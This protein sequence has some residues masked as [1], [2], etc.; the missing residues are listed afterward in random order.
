MRHEMSCDVMFRWL[1]AS[2]QWIAAVPPASSRTLRSSDPGP[3]PASVPPKRRKAPARPRIGSGA[4]SAGVRGDERG[5][6]SIPSRVP[7]FPS[8]ANRPL[9]PHP[10]SFPFVPSAP[11]AGPPCGG[12]LFR[13]Y[14]VRPC[15]CGRARVG[16][17]AVRA[18]DC[19]CPRARW[20][21]AGRTCPVSFSVVFSRRREPK[22][23]PDAAS[24][25][26]I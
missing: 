10:V 7:G 2:G 11:A 21:N 14:R 20:P 19:A 9:L 22:R 23:P 5:G 8:S 25:R 4:G 17:G 3:L 15:A 6:M 18:P 12:T 26:P 1:M 13:A 24:T 16:A